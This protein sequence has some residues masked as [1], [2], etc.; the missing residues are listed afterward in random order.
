MQKPVAS[1]SF[2]GAR[3]DWAQD[4]D[5]DVLVL[6]ASRQLGDYT[7]TATFD[8]DGADGPTPQGRSLFAG[9]RPLLP[10]GGE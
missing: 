4:S 8:H 10:V 9:C 7:P 6:L 3:G 2:A 1:S 5:I